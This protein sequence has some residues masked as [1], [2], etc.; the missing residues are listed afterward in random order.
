MRVAVPV[1]PRPVELELLPLIPVPLVV[2]TVVVV[3]AVFDRP[4]SVALPFAASTGS[5]L[6]RA[7]AVNPMRVP[8]AAAKKDLRVRNSTSPAIVPTS[9]TRED[10]GSVRCRAWPSGRLRSGSER[11][12]SGGGVQSRADRRAGEDRST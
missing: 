10:H 5:G 12:R 4:S 7:A 6:P 1:K 11:T 8:A 2:L 3:D 9:L